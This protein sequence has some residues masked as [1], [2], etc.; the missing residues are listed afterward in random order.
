MISEEEKQKIT[1]ALTCNDCL[2]W[3]KHCS[4]EC[5]RVL[6]INVHPLRLKEPGKYLTITLDHVPMLDERWYFRLRDV[7]VL[8]GNLRIKKE[9]LK[10]IN[11]RILYIKD[12]SLL[13]GM[14]CSGH[15]DKKPNF[16][17]DLDIE[18]LECKNP[19]C[20]IT[21]NCLLKYK[22]ILNDCKEVKIDG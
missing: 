15:P 11:G 16:C 17:K 12:C 18:N 1:D 19:R 2:S 14:F 20:E 22:Q 8:R 9:F 5:C 4:A 6:F 21:G 3:H 13:R 10:E 7:E